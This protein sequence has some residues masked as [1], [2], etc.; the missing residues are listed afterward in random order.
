MA[1]FDTFPDA[2]AL[3]GALLRTVLEGIAVGVYS[4]IPNRPKYPFLVIRRIGG[5][6]VVTERLDRANL[7]ID[8]FGSNKGEAYDL[9]AKARV[10]LLEAQGAQ[11]E[12]G[13]IASVE[14]SMGITYLPDLDV[15]PPIDRYVMGMAVYTHS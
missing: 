12:R 11:Y 13:W 8:S 15:S 4:S 5:V 1:E 10:A 7:Q 9:L 2:E 14:D 6:P 3:V